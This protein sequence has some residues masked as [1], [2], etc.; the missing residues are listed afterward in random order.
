MSRAEEFLGLIA[1][2]VKEAHGALALSVEPSSR[3]INIVKNWRRSA[4]HILSNETI[5]L[6]LQRSDSDLLANMAKKT[7]QY[8]RKSAADG[9]TIKRVR[10]EADVDACLDIYEQTARRAGFNL[11]T[12]QYYKDVLTSMGEHSPIF[13]AYLDDTPIAFLWLAV[14]AET[15]YELVR[16]DER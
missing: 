12:R 15:A 5:L 9:I 6:D 11:H 3:E 2:S 1:A 16:R 4:N 13:A 10:T 7:R 8:I 14:S